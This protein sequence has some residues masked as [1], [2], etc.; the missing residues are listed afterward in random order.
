MACIFFPPRRFWPAVRRMVMGPERAVQAAVGAAARRPV[1]VPGFPWAAAA[2]ARAAAP[3]EA[4]LAWAEAPRV[5]RQ[6]LA[7][8]RREVVRDKAAVQRVERRAA[9]VPSSAPGGEPRR[10]VERAETK[11]VLQ[12]RGARLAAPGAAGSSLRAAHRQRRARREAAAARAVRTA[13][14]PATATA[15]HLRTG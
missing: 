2:W 6:V 5:A 7:D 15:A 14:P 9:V 8:R 1:A 12:A 13:A 11:A 4:L 3:S 10:P